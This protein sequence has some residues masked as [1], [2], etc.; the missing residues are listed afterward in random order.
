MESEKNKPPE[1]PDLLEPE[2]PEEPDLLEPE[3]PGDIIVKAEERTTNTQSS[4]DDS[5]NPGDHLEKG[6]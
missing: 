3:N 6:L 2:N 4:N 1:E 5:E